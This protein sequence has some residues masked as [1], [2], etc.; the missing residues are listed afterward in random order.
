MVPFNSIK[1]HS[2]FCFNMHVFVFLHLRLQAWN[3]AMLATC[4]KGDAKT[5]HLPKIDILATRQ[6]ANICKITLSKTF[7]LQRQCNFHSEQDIKNLS[8]HR[9]HLV[10]IIVSPIFIGI[11][12]SS[13]IGT[14]Q[15]V[16]KPLV[17][18]NQLPL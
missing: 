4:L 7:R 13:E 2:I 5:I 8:T 3:F 12:G 14:L 9:F 1:L 16:H 6:P 17:I 10:T 11:R 18:G 15:Q